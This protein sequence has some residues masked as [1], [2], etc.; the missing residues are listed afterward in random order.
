MCNCVYVLSGVEKRRRETLS[1]IDIFTSTMSLVR[2]LDSVAVLKNYWA[3]SNVIEHTDKR[4]TLVVHLGK[5]FVRRRK[6]PP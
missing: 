1:K 6:M 4:R 5:G 2:C 3:D